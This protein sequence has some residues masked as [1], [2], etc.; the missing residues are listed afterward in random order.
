[1]EDVEK[2][3]KRDRPGSSLQSERSP[4]AIVAKRAFHHKIWDIF[5]SCLI[6][7]IFL[8]ESIYVIYY[9]CR[10]SKNNY[11]CFLVIG[12]VVIVLDG[13]FVIVK[14]QGK[15]HLWFSISSFT[16][17]GIMLVSI[18]FLAF[19]KFFSLNNGCEVNQNIDVDS[20]TQA[21]SFFWTA[22]SF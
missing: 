16:Y 11:F 8:A 12:M 9:L 13:V 18:W 1:M 14:R 21:R 20:K 15:E 7:I 6:R 17:T 22:V 3:S 4:L 5:L 10:F 19:D 2:N